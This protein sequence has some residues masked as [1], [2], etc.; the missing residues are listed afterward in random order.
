MTKLKLTTF[1]AVLLGMGIAS[2]A[3]LAGSS[4]VVDGPMSRIDPDKASGDGVST[5]RN[6]CGGGSNGFD[7]ATAEIE[8]K[9]KGSG[10][11]A[12]IELEGGVPNTLYTVWVRMKGAVH[13][14]VS[15]GGSP[16][17]AGGATPLSHT[18]GL[19]QLVFDWVVGPG[20]PTQPNGF[21]TDANGDGE[22]KVDLDFPVVN[23]AYPFNRMEHADHLL[24]QT[25][26]PGA[27]PI[28]TAIVTLPDTRN[29][30]P[31]MIRM[32]S[33]CQDQLGHG[34]SPAKRE[35]WFQYP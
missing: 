32:V 9:Q 8:I 11:E 5:V 25:K 12:E 31:F 2:T 3:A 20:S 33:H 26:N 16:M 27:N 29:E 21:I 13:G 34:L 6:N 28:P 17:T 1:A 22:F 18:D 30:G 35:A 19:A 14:G 4:K 23:G 7:G 10:S 24:A 15:Y